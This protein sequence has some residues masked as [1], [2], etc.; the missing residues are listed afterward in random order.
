[1]KQHAQLCCAFFK[2]LIP[3]LFGLFFCLVWVA[4]GH[5]LGDTHSLKIQELEVREG[6]NKQILFFVFAKHAVFFKTAANWDNGKEKEPCP[7]NK[8]LVPLIYEKEE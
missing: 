6:T 1:M 5:F 2:R 8:P 3:S 7:A 4:L